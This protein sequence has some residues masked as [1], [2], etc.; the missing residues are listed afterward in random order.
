[1]LVVD[2]AHESGRWWEDLVDEDEDRLLR[3]E[4]D[5][6]ADDIDKLANGQVLDESQR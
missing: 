2:R 1:V 3:S 6:L 4:L 5:A